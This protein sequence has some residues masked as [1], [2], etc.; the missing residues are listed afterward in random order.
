[1]GGKQVIWGRKA[2]ERGKKL[3]HRTTLSALED[4]TEDGFGFLS[5]LPSPSDTALSSRHIAL[6][7]AKSPVRKPR[8]I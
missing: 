3:V 8:S 2:G 5:P 4:T 7:T 1:M 6:L